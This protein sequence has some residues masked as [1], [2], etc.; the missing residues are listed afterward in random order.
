MS[1]PSW[2]SLPSPT[3]SRPSRLSQWLQFH[4]PSIQLAH[5]HQFYSPKWY[6]LWLPCSRTYNG[7]LLPVGPN[8]NPDYLLK[9][10]ALIY[11]NVGPL[12]VEPQSQHKYHLMISF[13]IIRMATLRRVSYSYEMYQDRCVLWNFYW[14]RWIIQKSWRTVFKISSPSMKNVFF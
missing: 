5:S 3:Q 13:Y 8:H 9:N 12:L 6:F 14:Y 1:P 11:L 10:L 2:T 4:V 7:S